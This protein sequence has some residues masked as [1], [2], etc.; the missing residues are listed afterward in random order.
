MNEEFENIYNMYVGDIYK[1]AYSY[2][3]SRQDAEDIT[4]KTFY[5]L[6][7]NRKIMNEC[8]KIKGWLIRVCVNECKDYLKSSWFKVSRELPD[9]KKES[10]G[11]ALFISLREM[12]PKY[13]LPLYFYY[14]EGYS[15][16][17]IAKIMN[18]S[19]SAIKMRLHRGK[20]KLREE[21][22]I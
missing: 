16:K 21:I 4:Q 7:N 9:I 3:V 10:P 22:E 2:V 15:I 18:K 12:D 13:R 20:E 11:S 17:E 14:Y 5:K 1:L 6:Y 19:E 8:E